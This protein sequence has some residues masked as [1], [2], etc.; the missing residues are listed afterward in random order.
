[1]YCMIS[2]ICYYRHLG[3]HF[4][5]RMDTII[6]VVGEVLRELERDDCKIVFFEHIFCG[7]SN[8]HELCK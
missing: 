1:M 3:A 5:S 7:N 4:P 8:S 6:M 2:Y